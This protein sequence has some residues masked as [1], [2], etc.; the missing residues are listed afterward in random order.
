VPATSASS[1]FWPPERRDC[2]GYG[3]QKHEGGAPLVWEWR[4]RGLRVGRLLLSFGG[5]M[6]SFFSPCVLPL[7]PAYLSLMSGVGVTQLATPTGADARRLLRSTLLF[8]LG[9]TIVFVALGATATALGQA[10]L[11]HKRALE[12][13]AGAV[14]VVMGV[15]IAGVVVP[16]ATQR[17]RRFHVIPDRLGG[18]APPIMGMA[19]AFGWTPCI[20]PILS[21]VI[22]T[23]STSQT[24]GRGILLLVAYSLGLGV[25][26][27]AAG[28]AFGRLT[29]VF[30][31]VTRHFRAIDLVAGTLLAAF[32]LVL[33]T[34]NLGQLS[35]TILRALD[36]AGLDFLTKI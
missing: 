15:V 12:R 3:G 11:E 7:V 25:P 28:V 13:V 19:F 8:V 30:G 35:S 31:W 36:A 17:E 18:F 21:V 14:I 23:A 4:E 26:F 27:V 20:G 10:L 29:S 22:A 33:L 6:L 24:L 16:A 32:G 9:F 1:P 34:G 5:G 2:P